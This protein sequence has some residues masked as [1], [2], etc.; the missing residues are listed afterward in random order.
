MLL[1]QIV[2]F[3]SFL[4][5]SESVFEPMYLAGSEGCESNLTRFYG[6][7]RNVQAHIGGTSSRSR[8]SIKKQQEE[9]DRCEDES[10]TVNLYAGFHYENH[11]WII[12]DKEFCWRCKQRLTD[13]VR[14]RLQNHMK[15]T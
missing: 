14:F 15:I 9:C 6:P 12:I 13:T 8:C 11:R 2:C 4:I 5:F 3:S 10:H 7:R 1:R